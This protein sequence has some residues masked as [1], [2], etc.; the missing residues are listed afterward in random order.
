MPVHAFSLET[1]NTPTGRMMVVTDQDGRLRALDWEDCELRMHTL[2][3]RRHG[4]PPALRAAARPSPARQALEAYF[5]GETDALS[6]V[7]TAPQGTDFQRVVWAALRRIP[8]GR[9]ISYGALAAGI[10]RPAAS[11]AVGAANGANPVAI[12]VPCH[13]VVGACGSLTGFGGGLARKR[14]L[15]DHEQGRGGL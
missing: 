6:D 7:P 3:R 4:S 9:T 10:G 5:E 15:L 14:W 1:L 12:V 13:R 11:R 2:L 8:A